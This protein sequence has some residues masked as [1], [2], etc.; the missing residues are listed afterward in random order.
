MGLHESS[1]RQ[2]LR[3]EAWC[4]KI[5]FSNR[6]LQFFHYVSGGIDL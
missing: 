5:I 2:W 6:L 4:S 1:Q 3:G